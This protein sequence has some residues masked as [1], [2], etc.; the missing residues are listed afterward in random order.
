MGFSNLKIPKLC[1][2]CEK[3]FEAKTV[4]TRFCSKYCSE[5]NIKKQKQLE[6][7][8]QAKQ[9]LLEQSKSKIAEVQSRPFI[10]VSEAKMLFGISKDTIHRLIKSGRVPAHNFGQ[11][12]TRVSRL[13]LE[14]L[15]TAVEIAEENT[16]PLEEQNYF[17]IGN[18]LTI[19]E[20]SAK[21][22]ADPGTV[23]KAIKKHKIPTKKVGSFVYVPK[24]LIN[25]I[26]DPQ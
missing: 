20:A 2:F 19:S 23:L 11:R 5:K 26:F 13:D 6:K 9:N 7:E 8:D 4:A 18:C 17:E 1:E 15:F 24:V 16:K 14:K 25:Q 3:P 12:L 10:S 22:N 21:F